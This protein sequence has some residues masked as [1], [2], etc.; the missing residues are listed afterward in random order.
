MDELEEL[1]MKETQVKSLQNKLNAI[2]SDSEIQQSLR[3]RLRLQFNI[4]KYQ[5]VMMMQDMDQKSQ[6][7]AETKIDFKGKLQKTR[8]KKS[9]I[10]PREG[11]DQSARSNNKSQS[12][13]STIL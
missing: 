3:E 2:A 1:K 6:E 5:I 4:M 9:G 8:I 11:G 10:T 12:T 7:V 13:I